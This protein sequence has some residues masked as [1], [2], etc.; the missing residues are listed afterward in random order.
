V[1]HHHPA[2][3]DTDRLIDDVLGAHQRLNRLVAQAPRQRTSID[4]AELVQDCIVGIVRL[5][6]SRNQTQGGTGL[7]LA[8]VKELVEEH[9]GAVAVA[10]RVP[11]PGVVF[12][13]TL[14]RL[15]QKEPDKLYD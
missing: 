11:P 6:D 2:T 4:L 7:G 1:A 5:D 3:V 13:I 12:T 15:V 9:D 8:L 14:P 10:D